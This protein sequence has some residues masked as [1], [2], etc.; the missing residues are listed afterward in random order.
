MQSLG[1]RTLWKCAAL[2][3]KRWSYDAAEQRTDA[4]FGSSAQDHSS[5]PRH[6][7]WQICRLSRRGEVFLERHQ[8]GPMLAAV[9]L[10]PSIWTGATWTG[11]APT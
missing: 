2:I 1:P 11:A 9:C 5:M 6:D 7:D 3:E 10:A 8:P 4:A